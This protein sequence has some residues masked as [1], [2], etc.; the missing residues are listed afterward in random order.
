MPQ[1]DEYYLTIAR[2]ALVELLEREL[3][4][5][6]LELEAKLTL[7]RPGLPRGL[8]P[9]I[10]TAAKR[11]LVDEGVLQ[12]VSTNTRGGR[13]ISVLAP[14]NRRGRETAFQDAAQRKR[15]LLA[16]YLGWTQDQPKRRSP[17][18]HAGEI[19]QHAS[20]VAAATA[21]YKLIRPE[22][23]PVDTIFGTPVPGGA[24][25]DA[26]H[27]QLVD[28]QGLPTGSVFIP[29]EVKNV[30]EWLYPS[31]SEL[32]QLLDKAVRL[33]A[34]HPT[35]PIAPVLVCRRAPYFT[36]NM[37]KQLGFFVAQTRN[38]FIRR[39]TEVL[40]DDGRLL[41]EVQRE[42]GFHDLIATESVHLSL[43]RL[44]SDTL[45]TVARR[46]AETF[47]LSAPILAR[48]A[49]ALRQDTLMFGEREELMLHLREDAASLSS[50]EGGW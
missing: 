20:L 30:R 8:N 9:H 49:S 42:L 40:D 6:A 38:Q 33:Q 27:L 12:Y 37:A 4:V 32:Y 36:M 23:G 31:A 25:D 28:H 3:A 13:A 7:P 45:P 29:I 16:R 5:V 46:T 14:A 48:Y 22:G 44:Y 47:A 17:I 50:F 10:L 43:A 39:V 24:L 11:E 21:G 2:D 19:V 41:R 26:A 34:L 1:Q 15:L 35:L 18:G